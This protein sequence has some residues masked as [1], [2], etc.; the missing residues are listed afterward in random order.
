MNQELGQFQE[1]LQRCFSVCRDK[2]A[3]VLQDDEKNMPAAQARRRR[4]RPSPEPA[5][6]PLRLAQPGHRTDRQA[7][8]PAA[9]H[10][11]RADTRLSLCRI[12]F[13]VP[14]ESDGRV[15]SGLPKTQR[16]RVLKAG[17]EAY[18]AVQVRAMCCWSISRSVNAWHSR[19]LAPGLCRCA[20]GQQWLP[21]TRVPFACPSPATSLLLVC[22]P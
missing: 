17:G 11:T 20:F 9:G 7:A 4:R 8:L 16:G 15:L 18:E 5:A 21:L 12:I 22:R 2:A 19:L 3:S 14:A 10:R 13:R 6:L 1:R